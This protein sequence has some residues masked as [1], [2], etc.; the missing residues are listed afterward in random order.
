VARMLFGI[1]RVSAPE[2]VW[3][4]LTSL[5]LTPDELRQIAA[6]LAPYVRP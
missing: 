2:Q 3:Q 5:P 1:D 6:N 4:S